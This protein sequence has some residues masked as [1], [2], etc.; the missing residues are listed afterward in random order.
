[1]QVD[2]TRMV[3]KGGEGK[4]VFRGAV[5]D[6][7]LRSWIRWQAKPRP[8]RS[9]AHLGINRLEICYDLP[10]DYCSGWFV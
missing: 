6:G 3:G 5:C 1:M 9:L 8:P 7:A 4:N 10:S 2:V